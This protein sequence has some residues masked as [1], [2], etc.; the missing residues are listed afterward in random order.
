MIVIF[1]QSQQKPEAELEGNEEIM[2]RYLRD[3]K[4]NIIEQIIKTLS[5]VRLVSKT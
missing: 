1:K 3:Q 5:D 4:Q 2:S